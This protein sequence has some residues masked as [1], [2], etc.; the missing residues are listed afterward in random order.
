MPNPQPFD[1][2][3][4]RK[5]KIRSAC[6]SVMQS[7]LLNIDYIADELFLSSE[8]DYI[9]RVVQLTIGLEEKSEHSSTV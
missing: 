2:P 7:Q 1:L 4:L 3:L 8:R 6:V 5:T 9:I